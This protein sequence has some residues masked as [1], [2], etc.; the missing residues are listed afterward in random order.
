MSRLTGKIALVTGAA[1]GIGRESALLF[2]A[3][4]ARVACV[5]LSDSDNAV[6][7]ADIRRA[8]GS[9]IALKA[10]VSVASDM[11]GVVAATVEE[12]GALH[13][14]FNNAGIMHSED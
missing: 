5:D 10:D 12:F 3:N 7:A 9:A 4:G 1:S 6:T 2:A 11:E 8:G 14:A 13:V